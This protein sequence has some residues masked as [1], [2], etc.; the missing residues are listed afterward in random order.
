MSNVI[1]HAK[2]LNKSFG[3][4]TAAAD[5]DV[6]VE[7]GS[8]LGL[9]GT[10]GAGKT[11]FVNMITGYLKPDTGVV[12][13]DGRDITQLPPRE[14]TQLGIC[15]SFQIPQLYNSMTALEN[16][17]VSFGIVSLIANGGS[18]F[19]KSDAIVPGLGKTIRQ[20]AEE[21]L[22]RFDLG[23]YRDKV[24]RVLPGGVRKVLDIAMA[25]AV[26][27]KILLL[28][29]PTSGVSAEEK[30]QIMDMVMKAVRRD[31][32]TVLFVEHDMEIVS[33]HAERVLAFYDGRII[34]DDVP[35]T[36]LLDPTVVR[37]IVGS[38]RAAAPVGAH[39]HA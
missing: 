11:T 37:H 9:I 18:L 21:S 39:D 31:N 14:I 27:P 25:M 28:D 19:T 13:F 34:A 17:E 16:L 23:Q 36:V 29:E 38:A 15:R 8:C 4:V 5:I 32:T 33:R 3:A 30:F 12:E 7:A 22:E 1:L 10:N 6:A 20:L 24:A 35:D 2:Q 26:R